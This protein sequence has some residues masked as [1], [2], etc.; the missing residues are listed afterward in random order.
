MPVVSNARADLDLADATNVVGADWVV[1]V[2]A[3]EVASERL[4]PDSEGA[5]YGAFHQHGCV[6]LR[7]ALPLP[8]VDAMH[9]EFVSQFGSLDLARMRD[10]AEKP[11]P[12]RLTQVGGARYDI[13]LRMTGAF[14]RTDVFANGLLLNFLR[15]LLGA[16]MHLNS[17]TAV[18]S[19]PN[20]PQQ[21]AHRDYPHLFFEPGV[22]T[23]LPVH[24]VNVVVPLIDVEIETGPTGVWLGS[25]RLGGIAVQAESLT[26]SA[27]RRGDCML[28]DYRTLHTG[29][30]NLSEQARPMLYM[31]YARPWFF[32][33][34]NHF[35][36]SRNPLDMPIEQYN[37]LPAPVR[38][39]LAR[40]FYYAMLARW[41]EVDGHDVQRPAE[42]PP[43]WGKAGRN[44][45][46][47]CGSGK[48]YKHC[49]GSLTPAVSTRVG[50]P[51]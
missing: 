7:G 42:D 48:R 36:R 34:H 35:R 49:H 41:S 5:A 4:S 45:P 25:H 27:L 39:L 15:P 13:A 20:A 32:D 31:V 8:T 16:D 43:S 19:H 21:R 50:E 26:I 29:L 37:N 30:P 24:A 40:A 51:N 47:P 14:G 46:C 38:P 6:L 12:N 9:R 28:L 1:E 23:R 18:V 10:Q 17:F 3:N 44:H 2:S 33:Q 11:A 22:G